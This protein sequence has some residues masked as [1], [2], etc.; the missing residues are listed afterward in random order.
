MDHKQT[1]IE[2]HHQLQQSMKKEIEAMREILANMHREEQSLVFNDKKTWDL[3]MQERADLILRLSDLRDLRLQATQKLE[4]LAFPNEK[5][6]KIS[7]EKILP[8][9]DENSCETLFLRDQLIALVD[10]MNLQS[11]RNEILLKLSEQEERYPQTQMEALPQ[12]KRKKISIAT[13]PPKD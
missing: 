9:E 1:W 12:G 10:R 4:L 3:L 2:T 5:P 6:E 7:L 11:A 13:L 8:L